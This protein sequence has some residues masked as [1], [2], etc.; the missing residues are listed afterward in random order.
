MSIKSSGRANPKPGTFVNVGTR[1]TDL[2][3]VGNYRIKSVNRGWNLYIAAGDG[4]SKPRKFRNRQQAIDAAAEHM[5]TGKVS[6]LPRTIA[7]RVSALELHA[8]VVAAEI[9]R[10]T[11]RRA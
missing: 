8:D 7:E 3:L 1:D 6:P 4:W 2:V 11:G 5:T 10:L 9:E